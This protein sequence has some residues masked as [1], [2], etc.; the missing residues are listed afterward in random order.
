M[1]LKP[2]WAM[3]ELP[4]CLRGKITNA[5]FHFTFLFLKISIVTSIKINCYCLFFNR[6]LWSLLPFPGLAFSTGKNAEQERKYQP[7]ILCNKKLQVT[8]F[9]LVLLSALGGGVGINLLNQ[10]LSNMDLTLNFGLWGVSLQFVS[11]GTPPLRR[12]LQSCWNTRLW[13]RC[14]AMPALTAHAAHTALWNGRLA[15]VLPWLFHKV[16]VVCELIEKY[17][18]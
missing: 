1:H 6:K 3:P 17:N 4:C 12:H 14:L 7:V 10:L 11:A 2:H 18:F 5:H 9:Y 8:D 13:P 16:T 15:F